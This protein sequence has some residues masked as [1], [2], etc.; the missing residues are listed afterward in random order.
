VPAT[1]THRSSGGCARPHRRPDGPLSPP[2]GRAGQRRP[3][4]RLALRPGG[5]SGRL[6]ARGPA[7]RRQRRRHL[8]R[9]LRRRA[10][11]GLH[12]GLGD[13]AS[14]SS[15]WRKAVTFFWGPRSD[16]LARRLVLVGALVALLLGSG[17]GPA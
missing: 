9:A 2:P 3:P 7:A 4:A 10:G 1:P 15:R 17:S 14:S 13:L 8:L 16:R 5:E 11:A 12:V 6:L